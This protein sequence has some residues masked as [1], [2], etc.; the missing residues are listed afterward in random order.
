M[1]QIER[2]GKRVLV[3]KQASVVQKAPAAPPPTPT[4]PPP[5]VP[6][7]EHTHPTKQKVVRAS[8]GEAVDLTTL[9]GAEDTAVVVWARSFG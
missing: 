4:P 5:K 1:R 2:L 8:S 9:W 3:R 7:A 6:R